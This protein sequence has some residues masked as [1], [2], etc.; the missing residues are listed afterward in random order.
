MAGKS[1]SVEP[2]PGSFGAR[3]CHLRSSASTQGRDRLSGG[4]HLLMAAFRRSRTMMAQFGTAS[5]LLLAIASSGV[6]RTEAHGT[7]MPG[8]IHPPDEKTAVHAFRFPIVS[9]MHGAEIVAPLVSDT[10]RRGMIKSIT[11]LNYL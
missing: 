2:L 7:G 11:A 6:V 8:G 1:I 3:R 10:P 5:L 4:F 9:S